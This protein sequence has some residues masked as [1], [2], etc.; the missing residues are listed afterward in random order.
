MSQVK[1]VLEEDPK[2][3]KWVD[4]VTQNELGVRTNHV[5]VDT[6]ES[7]REWRKEISGINQILKYCHEAKYVPQLLYTFTGVG[8]QILCTSRRTMSRTE[9]ESAFL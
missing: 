2:S 9:S 4:I 6:E 7:A 5:E 3:P 8:E 1:E